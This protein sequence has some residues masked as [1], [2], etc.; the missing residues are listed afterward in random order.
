M[1][2]YNSGDRVRIDIPDE[3]DPNHDQYHGEHGTI[4]DLL[5]DDDDTLSGE[6]HESI[7]YRIQLNGGEKIDV[8]Q[9]VVRPPIEK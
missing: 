2:E 6:R 4:V 9:H 8:R 7:I 1:P 3:T 5:E